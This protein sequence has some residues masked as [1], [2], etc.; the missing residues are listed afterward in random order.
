MLAPEQTNKKYSD[1]GVGKNEVCVWGDPKAAAGFCF[2]KLENH[3]NGVLYAI[4]LFHT[5][6]ISHVMRGIMV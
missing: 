5:E 2:S 4:V 6:Q 1:V 3:S